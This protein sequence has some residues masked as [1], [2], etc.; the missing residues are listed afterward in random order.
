MDNSEKNTNAARPTGVVTF[1]MTDI[2]GSTP[3]WER[4]PHLMDVA[5]QRHDALIDTA[6]LA[7]NGFLLR[8]RGE[9]DSTFS[10]FQ[11]TVDAVAAAVAAQRSIAAEPWHELTPMAV[12]MGIHCGD[13]LI[14]DGEYNGRTINR[15]ARV[16]S[17]AGGGQVYL[18][19]AAASMV[20]DRLPAD[21]ELRF[22]RMEVLRGIDTAE[23]IHELVDHS[24]PLPTVDVT[25][26]GVD[27]THI[28]SLPS[29]VVAAIPRYF[30]GRDE[31]LQ[32]IDE[33]RSGAV[34]EPQVVLLS[35]EPGAGKS[36]L[37]AVA[38]RRAHDDG[39]QVV[40]GACDEAGRVPYE[41]I[42]D[43]VAICVDHAPRSTLAEHTVVHG[44]ELGRLTNRL[45]ARLGALGPL[46]STDI[47][48]TRRLLGDAVI[49]LL[50]RMCAL[51]P[52]VLMVDDLQWADRNT[53]HLVEQI[54]TSPIGGLVVLATFRDGHAG[55]GD[56][57]G[58]LERLQRLSNVR[59]LA[60][61]G[62]G[63]VEMLAFLEGA[64][65]H[66]LGD[67]G[68]RLVQHLSSETAGNPFFMVEVLRL[69][70]Q[71][72]VIGTGPDGRW[73]VQSALDRTLSATLRPCCAGGAT[74][75]A[76]RRQHPGAGSGLRRGSRLRPDDRRGDD[77]CAGTGGARSPR[78]R[79]QVLLGTRAHGRLVRVLAR[80]GAAHAVRHH[81]PHPPRRT[82]PAG[83]HCHRIHDGTA[84]ARCHPG[85]PLVAYR[86]G[87]SGKGPAVVQDALDSTPWTALAPEDAVGWFE[88]TAPV[89]RRRCIAARRDDRTRQGATVGRQCHVPH[90]PVGGGDTRRAIG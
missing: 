72:Q 59:T 80:A 36:T 30:V 15:T 52:V 62:L 65:G 50:A 10:V 82:A 17:L 67:D 1:L 78:I 88:Q 33:A 6:V 54:A 69:L 70:V 40:F 27:V 34:T 24:R 3:L 25:D 68:P 85:R 16:R 4:A 84:G 66:E 74:R 64:A 9:G 89:L 53:L 83:S 56:F 71:E 37:A 21:T 44:G 81:Q 49:D 28:A 13:V 87:R 29:F 75:H 12:R 8:H 31:L 45:A 51:H 57:G 7:H 39:W 38:A 2:V 63:E 60:V 73:R 41:A 46:D 86:K 32:Q 76:G 35:G 18:S 19:G 61:G 22:L 55:R 77:R 43:I 5:L 47:D 42:R 26:D 58:W 11:S 90:H 48:T 79:H 20:S 23:A 14:R